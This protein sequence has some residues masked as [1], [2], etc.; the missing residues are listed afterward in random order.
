MVVIIMAFDMNI[1]YIAVFYLSGVV[2][3]IITILHV[4]NGMSVILSERKDKRF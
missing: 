1:I 2:I 4:D 3:I